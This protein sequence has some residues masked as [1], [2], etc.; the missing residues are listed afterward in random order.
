MIFYNL[1]GS[2]QYR[3]EDASNKRQV[4]LE[5]FQLLNIIVESMSRL[6]FKGYQV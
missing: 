6:S 3:K 1:S 2:N 5:K 4:S